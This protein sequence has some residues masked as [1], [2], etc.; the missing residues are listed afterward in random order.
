MVINSLQTLSEHHLHLYSANTPSQMIL[1]IFWIDQVLIYPIKMSIPITRLLA[2][3]S[4]LHAK[5][6]NRKT[7]FRHTSMSI[8]EGSARSLPDLSIL[9][10]WTSTT[11]SMKIPHMLPHHLQHLICPRNP[12][13]T[14]QG[15][16]KEDRNFH[17]AIILPQCQMRPRQGL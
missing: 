10:L 12:T 14:A 9:C 5:T 8:F 4:S 11:A 2:Q 13:T 17:P 7:V 16:V 3:P 1:W 6:A 15:Q